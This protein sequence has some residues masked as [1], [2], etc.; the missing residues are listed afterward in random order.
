MSVEVS[1]FL[2]WKCLAS[3]LIITWYTCYWEVFQQYSNVEVPARCKCYIVY[4]TWRLL[5]MFRVSLSP[6]FRST[7]QL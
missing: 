4:F 2:Y 3:L 1:G 7:K 6:I 5:Y